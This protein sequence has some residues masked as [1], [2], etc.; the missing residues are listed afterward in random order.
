MPDGR[1]GRTSNSAPGNGRLPGGVPQQGGREQ[2]GGQTGTPPN[3]TGEQGGTGNTRPGGMGGPGGGSDS[4]SS[5]VT[6]WVQE[7]CA[8]VKASEYGGTSSSGSSAGS[9]ESGSQTSQNSQSLYRLDA[10]DVN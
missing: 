2:G 1:A 6:A 7:H 9:S 10:S 4:V 3:G 5:E 8:A